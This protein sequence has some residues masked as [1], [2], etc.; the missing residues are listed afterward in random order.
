MITADVI[1]AHLAAI[2]GQIEL[3]KVQVMALRHAL[4]P[5]LV[6]TAKLSL[7]D[8]CYGIASSRCALQEDDARIERGSFDQPNA[9]QCKGCRYREDGPIPQEAVS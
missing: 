3:T 5:W 2:D 4:A 6:P 9:W 7:P 8:R 1:R